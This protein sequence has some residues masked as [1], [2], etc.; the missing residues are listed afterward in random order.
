MSETPDVLCINASR[1]LIRFNQPLL[2]RLAKNQSVAQ[3]DYA[4][5]L[6]EPCS[7]ETVLE[8]LHNYLSQGDR[9]VHLLGHG[10]SGLIGLSYA[11]RYPD[12][13]RSLSLLSVGA[14]PAVDWQAHYYVHRH[15]L[16]CSRSFVLAQV[17]TNLFG[18]QS[19]AMTQRLM[20]VLEQD[21]ETS[22][23]PHS[24]YRRPT[25]APGG[26]SV[27][28]FVCRGEYDVVI[29]PHA[30]NQWQP[31]LKE[32]DRLWE[33]AD[34]RHFFHYTH[35]NA[36]VEQLLDFWQ[37]PFSRSLTECGYPALNDS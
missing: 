9:P 33:C 27:P 37:S 8:L 10:V 30:F 31:W 11:R 22:P 20:S 32:G 2:K 17:V 12:R 14:Y 21:L 28:L 3:W 35:T 29:D 18:C 36:V 6:D 15:L 23:S 4:Q 1:S 24:L 34:G 26:V 16:N 7:L 5:S 25:I 13:V 19:Q